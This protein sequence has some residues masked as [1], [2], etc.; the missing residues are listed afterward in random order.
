MSTETLYSRHS[1]TMASLWNHLYHPFSFRK[2]QH[3]SQS[4]TTG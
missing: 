1:N 4:T 3:F 2:S